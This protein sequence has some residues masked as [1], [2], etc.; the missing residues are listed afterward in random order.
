MTHAKK[1]EHEY[2]SRSA[3]RIPR[4]PPPVQRKQWPWT[5]IALFVILVVLFYWL[6]I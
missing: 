5:L 3:P 1:A 4:I 6:L 2:R